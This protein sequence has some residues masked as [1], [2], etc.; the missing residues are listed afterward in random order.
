MNRFRNPYFVGGW[1]TLIALSITRATLGDWQAILVGI[2]GVVASFAVANWTDEQ[3]I[4]VRRFVLLMSTLAAV[5]AIFIGSLTL[6]DRVTDS[7]WLMVGAAIVA[8]ALIIPPGV[9][10]LLRLGG[11]PCR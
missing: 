4:G 8:A 10:L 1:I 2:L 7:P 11:S 9:W 6:I 5:A 3:P